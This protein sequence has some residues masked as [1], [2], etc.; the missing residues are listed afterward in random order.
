MREE[1]IF[2]KKVNKKENNYRKVAP[3]ADN[4]IYHVM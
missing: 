2:N 4:H 3:F 1:S